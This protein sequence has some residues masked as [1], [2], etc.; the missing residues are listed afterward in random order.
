MKKITPIITIIIIT[1]SACSSKQAGNC[2]RC[3]ISGTAG[4]RTLDT[5]S[6]APSSQYSFKDASGNDQSFFCDEK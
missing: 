6:Q 2:Y 5:C 4:T 3:T 1:L